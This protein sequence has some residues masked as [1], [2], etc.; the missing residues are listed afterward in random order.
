MES[1]DVDVNLI[2][3]AL[4]GTAAVKQWANQSR[5]FEMGGI[6]VPSQVYEFWEE[7]SGAC[8]YVFTMNAVTPQTTNTERTQPFM[9]RYQDRFDTFPV[10]SGPITYDAVRAY[11]KAMGRYVLDN[12]MEEVPTNEEMVKALETYKFEDGIVLPSIQFTPPEADFAHEPQWTSM[13]DTGVPVWQQWQVDEEVTDDYGV[14]HSFAPE[15]NKTSDY[16]YPD[17]IDY[18][19]GHPANQ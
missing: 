19:S 7:V 11:A 13:K 8:Q 18:P 9:R 16:T 3:Q 10:Y 4:T 5:D 15:Q 1:A 12:D 14:M 2:G 17:W 6:H